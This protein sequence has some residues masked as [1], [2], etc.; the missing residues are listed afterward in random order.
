MCV[1]WGLHLV[2][3]RLEWE[4]GSWHPPGWSL[5]LITYPHSTLTLSS[6]VQRGGTTA[7]LI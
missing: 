5:W 3:T 1:H 6:C 4:L 2:C 7:E